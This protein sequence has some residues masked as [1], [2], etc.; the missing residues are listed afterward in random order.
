MNPAED[1]SHVRSF[2]AEPTALDVTNVVNVA[3]ASALNLGESNLQQSGPPLAYKTWE[4]IVEH[5]TLL[6][7][8]VTEDVKGPDIQLATLLGTE[9]SVNAIRDALIQHGLLTFQ[10][11]AQ[12]D[13]KHDM[14]YASGAIGPRCTRDTFEYVRDRDGNRIAGRLAG[15]TFRSHPD[16]ETRVEAIRFLKSL[17]GHAI[18]SDTIQ[19]LTGEVSQP[20]NHVMTALSAQLLIKISGQQ[21]LRQALKSFDVEEQIN[22]VGSGKNEAVRFEDETFFVS[23]ASGGRSLVRA[24]HRNDKPGTRRARGKHTN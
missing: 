11:R 17:P 19:A 24:D 10:S 7:I 22:I 20:K 12:L 2:N 16:Q 18:D 6:D 21:N 14:Y 9:N 4:V 23:L 13:D 3:G 8:Q 15:I 5:M 1:K